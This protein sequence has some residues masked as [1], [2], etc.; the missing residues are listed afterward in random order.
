MFRVKENDV[1][2]LFEG[3]ERL[4]KE[5]FTRI[6]LEYDVEGRDEGTYSAIVHENVGMFYLDAVYRQQDI[7]NRARIDITLVGRLV[8]CFF[9]YKLIV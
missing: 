2:R 6:T 7:K 8:K 5:A 9:C 1:K 4:G 3:K